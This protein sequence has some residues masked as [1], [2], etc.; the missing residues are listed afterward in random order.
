M[1]RIYAEVVEVSLERQAE[2]QLA[3]E[4]V[5]YKCRICD[6]WVH[7]QRG[8]AGDHENERTGKWC[9]GSDMAPVWVTRTVQVSRNKK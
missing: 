3:I 8:R 2:F 5:G 6:A 4:H 7:D 1:S 9:E